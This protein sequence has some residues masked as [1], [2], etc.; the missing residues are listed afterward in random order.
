M[1]QLPTDNLD[2]SRRR[3]VSKR[4]SLEGA[5]AGFRLWARSSTSRIESGLVTPP[6]SESRQGGTWNCR[7]M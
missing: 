7:C 2:A 4:E 5:V 6:E 3:K 1:V